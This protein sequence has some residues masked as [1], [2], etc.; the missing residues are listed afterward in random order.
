MSHRSFPV[1]LPRRPIALALAAS[2]LLYGASPLVAV[3]SASSG[4]Q[5]PVTAGFGDCKND[6]SGKH[7]GYV[8]PQ[9]GGASSGVSSTGGGLILS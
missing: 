8:C 5:R 6:N 9:P 7:L 3:S 1:I 4:A 2:A